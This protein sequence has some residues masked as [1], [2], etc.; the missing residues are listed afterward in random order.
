M[1]ASDLSA[2][3]GAQSAHATAVAKPPRRWLTRVLIP[4][5]VVIVGVGLLAYAAR[6]SLQ[7]SI[8]VRTTPA[9]VREGTPASAGTS[10]TPAG[11]IVQAPGWIE[12]A[13]YA[14]SVPSLI[15]GVVREIAVL[16][17]ETVEAGQVVARL[18]DEDSLL[19]HKRAAAELQRFA[20]MVEESRTAVVVAEARAAELRDAA[21]RV[22]SLTGTGVVGEGE[23][24]ARRLRLAAQESAIMEASAAL[25]RVEAERDIAQVA[26]DE[27]NLALDRTVIR[28][29]VSGIVLSRLAEP[30][31]RLMPDATNPFAGVVVRLYDPA[32]LQARVDVPLADAAKVG[33]G[34]KVEV[35]TEALPN[36]V[37][38][39]VIARIVQEA[40]Q[41]K[42]TVQIKAVID[43]PTPALKA[44]MLIKARVLARG[45]ANPTGSAPTATW[46]D[47]G[48]VLLI[49]HAALQDATG[50]DAAVWIVDLATSTAQRRTVRVGR[51]VGQ[52]VEITN[53]LRPGDRVI[54]HPPAGIT[55]GAR[56]RATNAA[57][58]GAQHAAH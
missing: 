53:G 11:E 9:V 51:T 33:V 41:L 10:A 24:A 8:P 19:A 34:D 29:P 57:D 49:P 12:P 16:E 55:S 42:N 38:H 50:A 47:G 26:L 15:A 25:R 36:H 45:A 56:V 5:G 21:N 13:P 27:A 4:S 22:S 35:V 7:S 28:A 43:D 44:E 20:A 1:S 2:L 48:A 32:H 14:V 40:D 23:I 31:Q 30:G 58:E 39:A 46:A 6:E 52:D 54:L 3:L 17:G 37:F 18:I